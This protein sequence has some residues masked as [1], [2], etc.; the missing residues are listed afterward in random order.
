MAFQ[1]A[2]LDALYHTRP[3]RGRR[4]PME[5][6]LRITPGRLSARS[7]GTKAETLKK[8]DLTLTVKQRSKSDS[9]TSSVGLREVGV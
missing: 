7:F 2:P 5:Q 3:G 9:V 4:A 8:M 1:T 6:M